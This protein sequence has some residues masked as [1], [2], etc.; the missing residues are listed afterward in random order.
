MTTH[1]SIR[2]ATADDAATIVTMI[3]GLAEYEHE[4][5]AV[6]ATPEIIAAQMRSADPPFE[7]L[8]AEEDGQA[9]G[10]ALF[11]RAYSTWLA[12]PVLFLEDLFALPQYRGH[13]V[14]GALMRHLAEITLQRGWKRIEWLVLDW[15]TP[16]Q[17]FYADQGATHMKGWNV[18]GIDGPAL[19][20]MARN[21]T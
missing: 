20:R 5:G 14:G 11:F 12:T 2:L 1:C 9:L 19:E 21:H 18:W 7:C 17:G 4:L 15:N 6:Q 16:A 8:L 13:G 3:R 10:F